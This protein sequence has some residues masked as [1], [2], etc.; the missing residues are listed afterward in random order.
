MISRWLEKRRFMREHRWTGAHLSDYLDRELPES[1]R[2]RLEA[3]TGLCPEC[4][5][6]L[7]TLRRTLEGLRGLSRESPPPSDLT[8]SVIER[9]RSQG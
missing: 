5:R 8:D 9:L 7:A 4:G 2:H 1:D 3:H 6:M